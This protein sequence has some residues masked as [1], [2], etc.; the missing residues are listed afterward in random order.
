MAVSIQ[1]VET[2]SAAAE[3]G[4]RAGDFLH[5]VN[6]HPIAD[7]LDYRFY[8]TERRV[9][10]S[11][12]RPGQGPYTL[13][14]RKGQY[15]DIGLLFES[16]LMDAHRRCKNACV[17]CFIDQNPPGM[18]ESIY[19]KDDDARLSFLFGNYIT[20]TNLTDHDIDR[21]LQMHISPINVSVH[22]TDPE[23]RVRLMRN[24]A[25]AGLWDNLRRLAEGGIALNTQLVL[26][27]GINDGQ[28][29]K[30]SLEAL[31]SLRP[32]VQSVACVPVGLTGY[33]DGLYPL[34]PFSAPE[35]GAV[36]DAVD[37]FGD[38]MQALWGDR[39]AYP[40]DE[41]Y[42]RAERPVPDAAYY[43]EFAQLENGVGMWALLERE[44][45]EAAQRHSCAPE[46]G[47][48]SVATGIAAAPLIR[49]LCARAA[50]QTGAEI[51]VYP[52]ENRFFG[53]HITVAGLTTGRDIAG[54]LTGRAL[55]ERLLIPASMLRREGDL[56]LDDMTVPALSGRL[57]VPV[58]PVPV[59]GYALW[60]A[61]LSG[62][63]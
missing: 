15:D 7:I 50:E 63:E 43:G 27:P 29:L 37:A 44:F 11:L 60:D 24:P 34:R 62:G 58:V 54:Q 57:G 17:F 47:V 9:R 39:V 16:Y 25:A 2:G 8:L 23:V 41:F 35:A 42:L 30:N 5:A 53:G 19:F 40:A 6:G 59:D 18:R 20:L 28:V 32:G 22:A 36:I 14:L 46:G 38:R 33:R 56:F 4:V 1:G 61:I 55:G 10:L 48:L 45:E 26:C 52:V 21:I 13:R 12:E 31:G 49:R 3:A 51:L